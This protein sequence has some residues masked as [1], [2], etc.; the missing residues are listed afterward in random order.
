MTDDAHPA[1]HLE[2]HAVEVRSTSRVVDAETFAE[3]RAFDEAS[4]GMVTV[5]V[6]NAEGDVLYVDSADYG[7]WVLPGGRVE[8][9]EELREAAAREV[10]EETGVVA[11]VGDPLLVFHFSTHHDEKTTRNSLVLFEGVADDPETADDP[12]M[13][14]EN[15]HEARWVS[16]IPEGTAD[17]D[18]TLVQVNEVLAESHPELARSS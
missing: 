17:H 10:R 11:S 5:A 16:E 13:D 1:A 3:A 12:G 2:D 4:P 14:G 8:P 18:E 7:G 9:G 6:R 15:I